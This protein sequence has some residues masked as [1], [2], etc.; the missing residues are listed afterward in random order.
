MPGYG[1]QGVGA[2]EAVAGFVTEDDMLMGGLV[3][4][5]RSAT[6]PQ[7]A[8]EAATA[9]DWDVAIATAIAEAQADLIGAVRVG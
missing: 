7:A 6:M 2:S 1:A 5:S 4:A 8:Q 9:K 3:N